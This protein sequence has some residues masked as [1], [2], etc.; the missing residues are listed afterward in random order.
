MTEA[1]IQESRESESQNGKKGGSRAL[2][3]VIGKREAT[4]K[5]GGGTIRGENVDMSNGKNE[6]N[7]MTENPKVPTK[8][9]K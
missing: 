2:C 7:R 9:E 6:K 8:K 1:S 4:S 3:R 5:R